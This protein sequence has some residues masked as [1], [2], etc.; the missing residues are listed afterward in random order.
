MGNTEHRT[1]AI[2]SLEELGLREYEAKC[3]VGLVQLSEGT[4]KEIS[5]TASVPRSRVYDSL[6]RLQDRGLVDIRESNPRVYRGVSVDTAVQTLENEFQSHLDTVSDNLA[7]LQVTP[8]RDDDEFWTVTGEEN[9]TERGAGLIDR[10]NREVF[11]TLDDDERVVERSADWIQTALDR[12]LTTL[13]DVPSEAIRTHVERLVPGAQ[14]FVTDRSDADDPDGEPPGRTLLVDGE[15]VLLSSIERESPTVSSE[16]AVMGTGGVGSRLVS[17]LQEVSQS[18]R[19]VATPG[20]A[21][22]PDVVEFD[23]ND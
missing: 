23:A 18:R 12:G 6:D 7:E 19:H 8:H 2:A 16:T 13:V 1:R 3:F 17:M 15:S 11:V 14:V 5:K 21:A 22:F 9:V 4:A 10:A 20:T